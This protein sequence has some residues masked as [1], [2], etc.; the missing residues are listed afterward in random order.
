MV[1]HDIRVPMQRVLDV[2]AWA[3]GTT[4]TRENLYTRLG[5]REVKSE[6]SSDG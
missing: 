6:E 1:R 2:A 3:G 4:L 5:P